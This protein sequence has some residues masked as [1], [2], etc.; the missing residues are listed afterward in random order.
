MKLSHPS[1]SLSYFENGDFSEHRNEMRIFKLSSRLL[2]YLYC[3]RL[4]RK[5]G[6]ITALKAPLAM[7]VPFE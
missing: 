5:R 6:A 3:I 2:E 4:V 7:F 1:V